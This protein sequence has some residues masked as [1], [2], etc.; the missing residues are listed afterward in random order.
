MRRKPNV[1]AYA[2]VIAVKKSKLSSVQGT[3]FSAP[4]VSGF[5]A[6]VMQ[7]N[8]QLNN[9]EVFNQV[10]QSAHLFPY[11]DYAH[12]Y[13]IPQAEYFFNDSAET[14][15]NIYFQFVNDTIYVVIPEEINLNDSTSDN[16]LYFHLEN[17]KGVLERY[18]V[19]SVYQH[20]VLK[21]LANGILDNKVLRVHFR[22]TTIEHRF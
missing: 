3:S 11:Y 6:C 17:E 9:M 15:Q 1:S 8:P 10:E 14:D 18:S 21:F 20:D 4:L 7:I 19:V 2:E 5:T 13:G 16:L 22:G 12:G